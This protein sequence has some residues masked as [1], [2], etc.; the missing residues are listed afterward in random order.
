MTARKSGWS[1]QSPGTNASTSRAIGLVE[2]K[3][4]GSQALSMAAGPW[5]SGWRTVFSAIRQEPGPIG[6]K[7]MCGR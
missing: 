3:P 4:R 7:L 2:M 5:L 6:G 1:G